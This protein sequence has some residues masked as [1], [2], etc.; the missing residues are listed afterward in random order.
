MGWQIGPE[1]FDP[2]SCALTDDQTEAQKV[3]IDRS[4]DF[5]YFYY[6]WIE[7]Y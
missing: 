2:F 6:T 7:E 5:G 3:E 1:L 4:F